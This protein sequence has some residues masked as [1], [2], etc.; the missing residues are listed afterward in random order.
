[1]DFLGFGVL[2]FYR[3]Y[4]LGFGALGFY[5]VYGLGFYRVWK[6]TRQSKPTL[7]RGF[8]GLLLGVRLKPY[9]PSHQPYPAFQVDIH[10]SVPSPFGRSLAPLRHATAPGRSPGLTIVWFI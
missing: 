2:G 5:R 8:F 7:E 3:V 4:G 1:M 10:R 6:D 9:T